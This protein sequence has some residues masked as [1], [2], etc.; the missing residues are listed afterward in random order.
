[1]RRSYLTLVE[2]FLRILEEIAP[3]RLA[4]D[5]DNPG[6]QVGDPKAEVRRAALALDPSSEA[7]DRA[8]ADGC[9]L[10]IAHHPL[11]FKAPKSIT[12][13]DP[14][15]RAL[16]R[17]AA[18]GL[19]VACAHTNW[20]AV[21]VAL[22]L[23]SV[24]GLKPL[25]PLEDRPEPLAKLVA[26]TPESHAPEVRQA[27]FGAGAGVIGDYPD[28][29]FQAPG[30]GGFQVPTWGRPFSGTP[31]RAHETAETRLEIIL[32]RRLKAAVGQAVRAAHPYEEPA[33]EFYDLEA[34]GRGFGLL[35]VWDPPLAPGAMPLDR[36]GGGALWAGPPPG[37]VSLVA[38]MPG[39][40]GEYV[41]MAARA[42]ADLLITGDVGHHQAILAAEAG[43]PVL[44]AGHFQT[45]RPGVARLGREIR[46]RLERRGLAAELTVLDERPPLRRN[47]HPTGDPK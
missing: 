26:F 12:P 4:L 33:L 34:P 28:C 38:L 25:R 5:W 13:S 43:L 46:L 32:P 18:G 30:L 11:I 22:E 14:H 2:D 6:L 23:A 8:L 1:M 41:A 29:F 44:S 17:A 40:G 7:V 27:A 47:I 39:S 37:P 21:G 3:P 24:L 9:Q 35:G 31:G 45:E 36:L 20:D 16:W 15:T 10:L 42:G 19:A